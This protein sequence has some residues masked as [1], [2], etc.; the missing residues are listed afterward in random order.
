MSILGE[1]KNLA[2]W[3]KRQPVQIERVAKQADKLPDKAGELVGEMIG[4]QFGGIIGSILAGLGHD[5]LGKARGKLEG[6]ASEQVDDLLAGLAERKRK[7][8]LDEHTV[9]YGIAVSDADGPAT[10]V[11]KLSEFCSDVPEVMANVATHGSR[12]E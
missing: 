7:Y 3:A 1:L 6:Y 12:G 8:R 11:A 5:Q 2:R 4:G 10:I 9:L